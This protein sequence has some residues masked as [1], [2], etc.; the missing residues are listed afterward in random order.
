MPATPRKGQ[1]FSVIPR[2]PGFLRHVIRTEEVYLVPRTDGRVLIG[3]TVEDVGFD[4]RVAPETIKHMGRLADQIVPEIA[5]AKITESWAGL[6]PGTPDD[7]PILGE[8]EISGYFIAT[9]HFRNGILLAPLTAAI[10]TKLLR[11]EA[12]GHSLEAFSPL[13]FA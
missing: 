10:M 13:R 3:A 6:R 1:M 11:A 12:P 5:H 2:E 8:T 4:K 7:L 9:G